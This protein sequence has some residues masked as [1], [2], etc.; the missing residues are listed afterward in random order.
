[1]GASAP[2]S[3]SIVY[4]TLTLH[5][6]GTKWSVVFSPSPGNDE[7]VLRGVAATS[8][9]DVQAVGYFDEIDGGQQ[10][11][12]MRWDGVS[13]AVTS[14]TVSAGELLGVAAVPAGTTIA[15]GYDSAHYSIRT[16]IENW[17]GV[18]WK[19]AASPSVG[20]GFNQLDGVTGT[21]AGDVW[22]VGFR[23]NS[24]N[25]YRTLIEHHCPTSGSPP[26]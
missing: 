26:S 12:T 5:W 16:L 24:G 19:H 21:S 7:N 25:I 9:S 11:L 17:T 20:T 13:W 14:Q 8:S 18:E 15:V 22:A 4:L 2:A 23:P 1:V 3:G 6:D 10:P